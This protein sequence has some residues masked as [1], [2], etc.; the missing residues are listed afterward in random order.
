[1]A[2]CGWVDDGEVDGV[3]NRSVCDHDG[4]G[5]AYGGVDAGEHDGRGTFWIEV[6]SY[7]FFYRGPPFSFSDIALS[8]YALVFPSILSYLPSSSRT[9]PPIL[10]MPF[11]FMKKRTPWGSGRVHSDFLLA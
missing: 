7:S 3:S 10:I 5:R 4:E 9:G 1:M 11:A 6:Y 2:F 8:L